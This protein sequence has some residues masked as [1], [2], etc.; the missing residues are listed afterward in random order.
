MPRL[1]RPL[2]FAL[3]TT[4][5]FIVLSAGTLAAAATYYKDKFYPGIRVAGVQVGGM[6]EAEGKQLVAERVASYASH[7]IILTIPDI[8]KERNEETGSYPDIEVSGTAA[9]LGL[10]LDE[11]QAKDAAW[12]VG[13]GS[14]VLS[15]TKEAITTFFNGKNIPLLYTVE[16]AK[17]DEFINAKILPRLIPPAAATISVDGSVVNVKDAMP[18]QVVDVEVLASQ[19][20]TAIPTALDG[21][22]ATYLRVPTQEQQADVARKDIQPLA[23]QLENLGNTKFTFTGEGLTL[24][25]TRSE[26]LTWYT[27]AQDDNGTLALSVNET[28]ITNYLTAKAG[29]SIDVAKSVASVVAVLEAAEASATK[30]VVKA[31]SSRTA[32]LVAKPK[33]EVVAGS[34]TLNRFPG[35]YIEVNIK[36]QKLYKINGGQLE[37]VYRISSGKWETPTP[38]GTFRIAGKH[39]RPLSRTY[40]LYMPYWQNILGTAD[41]GQELPLGAYGLHELPERRNGIKEGQRSLGYRASHG[42]VRLGIGDAAEV[43]NWTETGTPV[44]IY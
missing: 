22:A 25:P 10:Q 14:N 24:A 6:S 44:V 23:T 32:S 16:V 41:N 27:V 13:H 21:E 29:K 1:K 11:T 38:I 40:N 12:S 15:W 37:K 3:I 43:Y 31:Q 42:C 28:A 26:V 39:L 20:A 5:V 7:Q 18:G 9:E 19:L 4:A 36:E 2:K 8:T 30:D 33:T 34:Y 17:T 35:K